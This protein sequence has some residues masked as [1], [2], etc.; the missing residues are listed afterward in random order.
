VSFQFDGGIA[1]GGKGVVTFEPNGVPSI[2][3]LIQAIGADYAMRGVRRVTVMITTGQPDMTAPVSQ[4]L[5]H[6][7][8]SWRPPA[9]AGPMRFE[10]LADLCQSRLDARLFNTCGRF[11]VVRGASTL[12]WTT[13]GTTPRPSSPEGGRRAPKGRHGRR[14]G[15]GG[16]R[17]G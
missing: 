8:G 16:G 2:G 11:F 5:A 3:Q 6:G 1:V 14:R 7:P 4:A 9:L 12:T 17:A 13:S 15:G 10:I